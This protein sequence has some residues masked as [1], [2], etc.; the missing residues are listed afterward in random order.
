[1][2]IEILRYFLHR[3]VIRRLE[4][5]LR[6]AKDTTHLRVLYTI[7]VT[8]GEHHSLHIGQRSYRLLQHRLRLITIEVTISDEHL[9]NTLLTAII[10]REGSHALL[11]LMP[12][13]EVKTLI[14][15]Y[16]VEPRGELRVITEAIKTLPRLEEHVLQHIISII[17]SEDN[18]P[19]MPIEHL[20]VLLHDYGETTTPR[21][22][23]AQQS[24]YLGLILRHASANVYL[25]NDCS[26]L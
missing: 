2:A 7:E 11:L 16:A 17:V 13:K 3:Y 6:R 8:H 24:Y 4:G 1:M 22:R 5:T 21:G 20:T 19:H 26:N 23:I 12:T 10:S 15:R 18:T 14:H 9:S 25:T